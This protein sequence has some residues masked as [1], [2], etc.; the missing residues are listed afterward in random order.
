MSA[1]INVPCQYF[2][3]YSILCM[4]ENWY[5]C[6]YVCIF[7]IMDYL[8]LYLLCRLNMFIIIERASNWVVKWIYMAPVHI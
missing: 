7:I 2:R 1:G 6:A 3:L 8:F 5:N 4:L